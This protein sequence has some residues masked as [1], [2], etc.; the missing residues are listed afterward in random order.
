MRTN[1][2]AYFMQTPQ[3]EKTSVQAKQDY[4]T[5]IFL[6]AL[7]LIPYFAIPAAVGFYINKRIVAANPDT[8]LLVTG[9]IFF[10]MYFFSWSIVVMRY[11]AIRRQHQK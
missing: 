11:K 1:S 10:A 7:E 9:A 6:F 5:R 3:N 8:S 4:S 2:Q